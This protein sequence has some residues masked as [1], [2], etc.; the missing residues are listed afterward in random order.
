MGSGNGCKEPGLYLARSGLVRLIKAELRGTG[1]EGEEGEERERRKG[2]RDRGKAEELGC[3]LRMMIITMMATYDGDND[4]DG[5]AYAY[6]NGDDNAEGE[7]TARH[8]EDD[9]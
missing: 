3:L 6:D 1:E 4:N 9:A 8:S 7:E 2:L 5:Y